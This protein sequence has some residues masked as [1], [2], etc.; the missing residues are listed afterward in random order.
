MIRT[1]LALTVVTTIAL[2]G[3]SAP[4]DAAPQPLTT[5]PVA[6]C[7]SEPSMVLTLGHLHRWHTGLD[8]GIPGAC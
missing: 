2:V 3:L 7:D 1:R 8:N 5:G 6:E 4:A